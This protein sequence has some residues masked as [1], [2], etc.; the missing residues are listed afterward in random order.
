MEKASE[1]TINQPSHYTQGEIECITYL[2]ANLGSAFGFFLEGS[3]KKYM[4][5]FRHKH[6]TQEG[7]LNDL[8]KARYFLDA[9][10]K[11]GEKHDFAVA[12]DPYLPI[13]FKDK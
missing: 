4:H 10:I 12:V 6:D 1:D 2:E 7:K 9:L 13:E 8:R 3:I 5:R 11:D